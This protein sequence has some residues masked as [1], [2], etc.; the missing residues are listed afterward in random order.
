MTAS[1]KSAQDRKVIK[2]K[3][4]SFKKDGEKNQKGSR[5][6]TDDAAS[7]EKCLPENFTPK[8]IRNAPGTEQQTLF[9]VVFMS[10]LFTV[11]LIEEGRSGVS[12]TIRGIWFLFQ[13]IKVRCVSVIKRS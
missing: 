12:L 4:K 8:V 1:P 13:Y 6:L 5:L 3:E 2:Y 10:G 9:N 7:L 11:W